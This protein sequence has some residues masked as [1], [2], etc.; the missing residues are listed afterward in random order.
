MMTMNEHYQSDN[1][2]E[3]LNK[4]GDE[5]MFR[6]I[7]YHRN[8]GNLDIEDFDNPDDAVRFA[9]AMASTGH[10]CELSQLGGP[11]RSPTAAAA[12]GCVE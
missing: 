4:E 1:E 7:W 5:N 2:V 3:R 6:V 12:G 8:S 9:Q 10:D 11:P